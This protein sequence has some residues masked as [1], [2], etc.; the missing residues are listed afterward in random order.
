MNFNNVQ[1]EVCER[2]AVVTMNRP[3]ALN[4]LNDETI[5]DLDAVINEIR[6]NADIKGAIITGAGKA[7]VAGADIRQMVS[8][9]PQQARAYMLRSQK[10]F[11]GIEDLEKPFLAA[12][13]GYALGGGC[14]LAMACDFRFASETAIFGQPEIN[15]GVIPGFGGTQRL[16]RLTNAGIAKELLLS[17]RNVKAEEAFRIGL[18]NRVCP[19]AE[20]MN[21]SL[22]A[23]RAIVSKSGVALGYAKVAVNLGRDADL[24]KAL[25]LEANLISLCFAG[26]DQKEG[27]NAF[28]EKR[29]ARFN[30]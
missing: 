7:F 27:M 1:L 19:A 13:N 4:A 24:K 12:V 28:L 9:T 11:N 22:S 2:V 15:L 6:T 17:G 25:E 29:P 10:V 8:Y 16:A 21:E 14:E 26:P 30:S 18:V 23:M 3:S 5:A 20:L